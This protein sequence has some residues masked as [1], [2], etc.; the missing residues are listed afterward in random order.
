MNPFF[1]DEY[2]RNHDL[3]LWAKTEK[4]RAY[5]FNSKSFERVLN[6]SK[7][8]IYP[9]ELPF[10]KK[11]KGVSITL[12]FKNTYLISIRFEVNISTNKNI[13]TVGL[14]HNS[15]LKPIEI[16][17]NGNN[18]F[19]Y[20]QVGLSKSI[21]DYKTSSDSNLIELKESIENAIN[22]GRSIGM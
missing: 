7:H 6:S 5:K 4:Y 20:S 15:N 2:V 12:F 19:E 10:G 11:R 1:T 14:L 16:N 22:F 3:N 18:I 21:Y 9:F 17:P 13:L 8:I